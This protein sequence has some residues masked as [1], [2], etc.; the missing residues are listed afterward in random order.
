MPLSFLLNESGHSGEL[1]KSGVACDFLDQPI[2]VLAALGI[3]D[4]VP[5]LQKIEALRTRH[6]IPAGEPGPNANELACLMQAAVT[7]PDH[8]LLTPWHFVLIPKPQRPALGNAFARA[9]IERDPGATEAQIETAKEK[10]DRAPCLLL[11]VA[12]L[13]AEPN[14]IPHTERLI[15]LG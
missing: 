9:L 2:F 5:L 14:G 15:S 8:G 10:A 4:E 13:G 1:I 7:A 12:H 11:A 6:K 3:E